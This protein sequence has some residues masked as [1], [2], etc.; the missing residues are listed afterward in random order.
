VPS[1][2][3]QVF[4]FGKNRIGWD[5]IATPRADEASGMVDGRGERCAKGE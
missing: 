3:V 1:D 5:A 2:P 4:G